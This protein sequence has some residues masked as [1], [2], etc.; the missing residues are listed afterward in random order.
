MGSQDREVLEFIGRQGKTPEQ[1]AER[2]PGFDVQR[3]IR[4]GLARLYRIELHETQGHGAPP[5]PDPGF[6][7]LTREG[8]KAVG[9]DPDTLGMA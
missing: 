4:A 7:V 9:I 3:L 6:Y 5:T 2:F 1:V 8:A